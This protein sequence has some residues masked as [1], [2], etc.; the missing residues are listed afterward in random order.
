MSFKILVMSCDKNSDLWFPFYHCMEKYWKNHP[1]IIYCT[2]T[3]VNPYY[4]T[5]CVDL[6][7]SSWT[8]RVYNAVKQIDTKDILLMCDDLFIR[9]YVCNTLIEVLCSFLIGGFG[10]LNMEKSFDNEDIPLC[11]KVKIRS[12]NGRFKTSVMCQLFQRRVMLD[13]FDCD[14]DPW[15]FE[16]N[17][18]SKYYQFLISANGDFINW[19]YG[20]H[21][22]FGIKKGQWCRE[23]KEFFD[24]EGIEIDYSIR[25]FAN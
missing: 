20:E 3:K 21:K 16:K 9:D 13:L 15:L 23:C 18:D 4:K 2:E 22:W 24:K 19:G 7:I 14:I 8:R 11:D 17:N 5:I 12:K 6:P 1:E 25:G 10:G